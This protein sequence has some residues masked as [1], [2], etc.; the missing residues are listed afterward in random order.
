MKIKAVIIALIITCVPFSL[1]AQEESYNQIETSDSLDLALAVLWNDSFTEFHKNNP[2][3]ADSLFAGMKEGIKIFNSSSIYDLG[4]F[5]GIQIMMKSNEML[6]DGAF[7]NPERIIRSLNDLA[8]GKDVGM[9]RA[10]AGKYLSDFF[11][12]AKNETPDTVSIASQEAFLNE[13]LARKGVTK[14]KSGLLFEV[15][16][17]GT[18][19]TPK[20][21][22][23]VIVKYTGRL[24]DGTI[25][26]QTG[27]QTA[28]FNVDQLVPGFTEGLKMMKAGG[29]YRMF[30]PSHIGY[31]SQNIQ[32]VI[33]GNSVLDFTVELIN[34]ITN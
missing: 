8:H 15:L 17:E 29:K 24:S 34:V 14:T 19:A 5:Q 16:K 25:F 18:G 27:N 21:G 2:E 3:K 11:N 31:G 30:I 28:T 13:Q 26:D 4:V 32:G 22:D 33:P 23:E 10:E 1:M 12:G 7:I 9:N 20:S 6:R